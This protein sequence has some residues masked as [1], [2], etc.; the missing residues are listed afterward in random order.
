MDVKTRFENLV[1]GRYMADFDYCNYCFSFQTLFYI[2]T[3]SYQICTCAFEH[4]YVQC[5]SENGEINAKLYEKILQCILKGKCPHVDT[6]PEDHVAETTISGMQVAVAAGTIR[7]IERYNYEFDDRPR[8]LFPLNCCDIA[9]LKNK[10][11]VLSVLFKTYE[12]FND[13]REYF[14]FWQGSEKDKSYTFERLTY[15]DFCTRYRSSANLQQILL[16]LKHT[17]GVDRA[18]ENAVKSSSDSQLNILLNFLESKSQL[19]KYSSAEKAVVLNRPGILGKVLG[20]PAE[21]FMGTLTFSQ[22]FVLC[23]ILKRHDCLEVLNSAMVPDERIEFERQDRVFLLLN[24]LIDNFE[25]IK[26]EI[27]PIL[28]TVPNISDY[29][30]HQGIQKHQY[31]QIGLFR[32]LDYISKRGIAFIKTLPDMGISI[33]S[34]VAKTSALHV[35]LYLDGVSPSVFRCTSTPMETGHIDA[36]GE[37]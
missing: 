36:C 7:A 18:L 19:L 13:Y 11:D 16:V 17:S 22:L 31:F 30:C 9:V 6:A 10:F 8:G 29:V 3:F 26:D 1:H 12:T 25:E 23:D 27:I 24:C 14:L 4:E 2:D 35:L 21:M 34:F 20:H 15:I 37:T 28:R 33:E 32:E 5:L